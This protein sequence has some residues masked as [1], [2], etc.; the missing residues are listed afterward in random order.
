MADPVTLTL[1]G[2]GVSAA[3]TFAAAQGT[4]QVGRYNKCKGSRT[5][6]RNGFV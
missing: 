5:K 2:A 1:I 6:S 3:G 4:K